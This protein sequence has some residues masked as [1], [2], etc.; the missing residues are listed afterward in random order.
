MI[1][2]FTPLI[3]SLV[4]L[5]L[6]T[7]LWEH[8]KLPYDSSNTII[9]E[10]YYKKNNPSNDILRFLIFI[11]I[12]VL[13]FTIFYLK[14]KNDV[15]SLNLKNKD[16]FL[17][18][19]FTEQKDTLKYYYYFI[20]FLIILEFLS[21]NFTIFI[22]PMDVF[23]NGTYLVP[24]MN[25][26]NSKEFFLATIHDYGFVANNIGLIYNY[27][28]G[29]YTL[30][31]IIFI[32][33]F[34]IFLIKFFLVLILK[35]IL[36]FSQ[37]SNSI[38]IVFF[39]LIS[40]IA[41]NLPDY[42]DHSKYFNFRACLY[43][44][45]VF[46]LGS[47]ICKN[48]DVNLNLVF[49]GFFSLIS[50]LWW[51]DIGAYSN[52]LI[53]LTLIYL[54][55]FKQY[56][57]FTIILFSIFFAWALFIII[58]PIE[59]LK[60]FWTQLKLVYSNSYQ[61]L[62]GLEYKKPFSEQSSRWTKALMLIYFSCL[63]LIIF[64]FNK[65]LF[66]DKK[67]KIFLNIFFISGIFVFKTA[68]MR[69]DPAHIKYSSGIYTIVFLFLCLFFLFNYLSK[70]KKYEIFFQKILSNNIIK[71]LFIIVSILSFTGITNNISLE[72][73]FLKNQNIFNFK[74]N[75]LK[76]V[77]A[78]DKDFLLDDTIR[79]LKRYEE[80]SKKD[81][82]I[83]VLTDDIAF[84]YLLKKKT[85]TQSYIPA[86]IISGTLEKRFIDQ[87]KKSNPEIILYE[88][89]INILLN[90]SN[91]PRIVDFINNN[92]TFFENFNGYIFYKKNKS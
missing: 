75:I 86:T 33:L 62:L 31:S 89:K 5:I 40:L 28:F 38:K 20:I 24:P 61:Y 72:K 2:K 23:H 13:I 71:I 26:L 1:K 60:E 91:M 17:N 34:F 87:L 29:Y 36:N 44:V 58:F 8:I 83:Q 74:E 4:S 70:N 46:F 80:L 35:K 92:Y 37:F 55:I 54:L 6:I 47:E 52:A 48:K 32:F 81:S 43:L 39:L 66:L 77:S 7:F 88:S 63:M 3:L 78:D 21:V 76:L 57:N 19:R 90:K 64:N 68:L 12:P 53:F 11:G 15:L 42:Y 9:G 85:C 73:N 45:F 82:C 18:H 27:F 30:G 10:Y 67:I 25:Y 16:F 69:S 50:V 56:K 41:V 51:F 49:V 14:N 84:S 79:V 22:S 65:N 59:E